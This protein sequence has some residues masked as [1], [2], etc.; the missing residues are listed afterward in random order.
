[1]SDN[2]DIE[3]RISNAQ[4]EAIPYATAWGYVLPSTSSHALNSDDLW[5]LASR[6][7]DSFEFVTGFHKIVNSQ[8]IPSMGNRG[9]E[10]RIPLD[11]EEMMG[12]GN[13]RPTQMRVGFVVMKRGYL[14]ERVEFDIKDESKVYRNVVLS[15]DLT[16]EIELQPYMIEYER[17]RYELS[18]TEEVSSNPQR[19]AEL[20]TALETAAESAIAQG[21]HAA[22]ARIYTRLVYA[23]HSVIINGKVAGFRQSDP[24]SESSQRYLSQAHRLDPD[25]I[26]ISLNYL[27]QKFD[28]NYLASN[29]VPMDQQPSE[30][31][32]EHTLFLK[33][34]EELI[35]V[36]GDSAW[37]EMLW[38]RALLYKDSADMSTTSNY[39]KMWRALISFEP[40]YKDYDSY[41]ENGNYIWRR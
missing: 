20:R 14:P 34:F 13:N 3:L 15:R 35:A 12:Y 31:Q 18:D 40:K 8:W 38:R 24:L 17:I 39:P 33:E 26:Y 27:A 1:M 25:N 7:K 5:R 37:P 10:L 16:Q 4:G 30:L 9:G 21:D 6:Y 23:P 22:A 32:E 29:S 2:L 28:L 41:D 11:Y 19:I 36:A